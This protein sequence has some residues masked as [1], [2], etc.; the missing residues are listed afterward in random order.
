MR[1]SWWNFTFRTQAF[2]C[3]FWRYPT[4]CVFWNAIASCLKSTATEGP[5]PL[6]HDIDRCEESPQDWPFIDEII[7]GNET[8][9]QLANRII[10]CHQR[11]NPFH[12][13]LLRQ[14]FNPSGWL[15]RRHCIYL[16][17]LLLR[18]RGYKRWQPFMV[19]SAL[20]EPLTSLYCV[21][22]P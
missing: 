15:Y 10:G 13:L 5:R 9:V 2:N 16:I 8:Y 19:R 17:S 7:W 12:C 21:I 6:S 22:V 18:C 1:T 3:L 4:Q 11:I 20:S 14:I